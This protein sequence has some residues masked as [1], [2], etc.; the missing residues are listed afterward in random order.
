MIHKDSDYIR[1]P[2]WAGAFYEANSQKLQ[3][4]VR[5][6][7]E[8]ASQ[9]KDVGQTI[10]IVVPHAG[11]E[12]SGATAA[13]AYKLVM[14]QSFDSVIIIA[15][16][17]REWVEGISVF[18]G[19]AYET[20]LGEVPV[21]RQLAQDIESFSDRIHLSMNGHRSPGDDAEHSLEVQL[22]FLQQVFPIGL[23]I[24]PIVFRDYSVENCKGLGDAIAKAARKKKVLIVASS[25]LY[26]G[27]SYD[28]CKATDDR[29][30]AAIEEFKPENFCHGVKAGN[31]QAC[32]GGPIAAL[33]FAGGKMGAETV[34]V[35]ARTNSAEVT[36]MRG[37]YVVGYAAIA[38]SKDR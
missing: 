24:V 22:P 23:Q 25:D 4:V 16:S 13:A 38:V 3:Q 1:K 12:Y 30:L 17:H 11:F 10:G 18:A 32:G 34:K 19:K 37:G 26:H 5:K 33:L 14:G 21:D 36:G 28:D 35:V 2:A 7:L 27:Y 15:P 20:P 6:S 31:Y 9:V 8:N 29:T